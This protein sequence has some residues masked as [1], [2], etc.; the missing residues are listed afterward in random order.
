[1]SVDAIVLLLHIE[2]S[3]QTIDEDE[4]AVTAMSI[5]RS[6]KFAMSLGK[7]RPTK[8]KDHWLL[9]SL[10]LFDVTACLF[11]CWY[12]VSDDFL[13]LLTV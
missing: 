9:S 3:N 11:L 1:V 2:E 5:H 7:K 12:S 8:D 6:L 10:V 4:A 13:F